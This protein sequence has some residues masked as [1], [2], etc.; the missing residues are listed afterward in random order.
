MDDDRM[1]IRVHVS[2][3]VSGDFGILICR[4]MRNGL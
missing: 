4:W 1:T 2:D 3:G